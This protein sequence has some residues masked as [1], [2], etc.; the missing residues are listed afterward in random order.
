VSSRPDRWFLLEIGCEEIPDGMILG[1]LRW[2][3]REFAALA[4]RSRLGEVRFDPEL[5][6]TPRRLALRATGLLEGQPD[7]ELEVVGPRVEAAY[8]KSGA[9]TRALEGFARAQGT[10]VDQVVRTRTP[11]GECVAARKKETG[12]PAAAVLS[13]A[14][15]D[16]ISGIPFAK[17]MR[18]GSGSFRFAR[19]RSFLSRWPGSRPGAGRRGRAFRARSRWRSAMPASMS[20]SWSG[21]ASWSISPGGSV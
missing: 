15:P 19:P 12:R 21:T 8:D 17:T 4:E 20:G 9:P 10:T 11:K 1:A 7:R 18:W 5:L 3:S 14:L 6:G 13:E 16:L 2:L